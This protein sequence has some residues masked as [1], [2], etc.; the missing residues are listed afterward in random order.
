MYKQP[1]IFFGIVLPALLAGI[2][3]GA[4]VFVKGKFAATFEEKSTKYEQ[5]QKTAKN[6]TQVESNLAEQREPFERWKELL[7]QEASALVTSNLRQI[8]EKLPEKEFQQTA[9]ERLSSSSG[10]GQV[11]Q[12]NSTGMRF[13]LRGTYSAV[14]RALL[15]LESRMPNLQLQELT[16]SPNEASQTSL[17]NFQ[18]VYTVWEN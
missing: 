16:I 14:Q 3:I 18:V 12:Q 4:G 11:S 7:G 13:N 8:A 10:F 15:E 6:V 17:L 9:F 1:I 5:Y 2:L